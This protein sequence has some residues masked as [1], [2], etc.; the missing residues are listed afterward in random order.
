MLAHLEGI[1]TVDT[2]RHLH[3]NNNYRN[4]ATNRRSQLVAAP[5]GFQA[6]M[7]FLCVFHVVIWT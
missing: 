6:K 4:R 7:H 2:F 5:L 3:Q 1:R